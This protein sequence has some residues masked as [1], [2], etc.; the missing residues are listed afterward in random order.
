VTF[1]CDSTVIRNGNLT[2]ERHRAP[3]IIEYNEL[4][5]PTCASLK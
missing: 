2:R 5:S 1:R 4:N 3:S